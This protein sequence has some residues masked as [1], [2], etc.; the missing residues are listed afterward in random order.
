LKSALN[1]HERLEALERHG[2]LSRSK[3][4]T[5]RSLLLAAGDE[6]PA[7]ALNHSDL[8]LKNVIVDSAGEI[9]AI[10]DWENCI[11]SLAPQ[12]ELSLALHDLSID[13]TQVFL[14]GYGLRP[15]E[16]QSLAPVIKAMNLINYARELENL[17]Q[18]G[19]Q[20]RLEE[21]RLR[22]TGALDLYSL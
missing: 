16:F 12:W 10:L 22:L 7:P 6:H 3:T 1:L 20:M 4:E 13:E 2:G 17:A 15:K 19:D 18:K 14:R 8:R 11:S 9:I 5:I 21:Y